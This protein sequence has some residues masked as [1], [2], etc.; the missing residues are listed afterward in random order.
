MRKR[1]E[2]AN[3][4]LFGACRGEQLRWIERVADVVDVPADRE[5]ARAGDRAREF[6]VVLDGVVAVTDHEGRRL[7]GA[8][9]H[10]GHDALIDDGSATRT[11]R[12][13]TPVRLLVFEPRAFRGLLERVPSVTRKLLREL[14]V[15]ARAASERSGVPAGRQAS[16]RLRAVS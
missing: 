12:T 3:T 13:T 9:F 16:R 11:V 1:T 6:A 10:F 15:E 8:G 2:I 7:C 4:P 5:L 14:V